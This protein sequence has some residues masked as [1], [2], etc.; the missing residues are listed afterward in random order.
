[1]NDSGT[2][3]LVIAVRDTLDLEIG[4]LGYFSLKPGYYIYVGSAL[5]GLSGRLKRYM[6]AAKKIHWH[7][8]YLM[9]SAAI[10]QVW[11]SLSQ[12]RLECT[13]NDIVTTLPGAQLAVPG[14]GASD[15]RCRSHLTC[16][17]RMPRFK[18]FEQ[19]TRQSGLPKVHLIDLT[20]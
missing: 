6:S 15:C 10:E 5:G 11:F 19:R 20:F 8:D 17:P 4:R 13:W 12:D 16:Y 2:Y 7:I 1:M 3:A 14:F 9:Q 18:L